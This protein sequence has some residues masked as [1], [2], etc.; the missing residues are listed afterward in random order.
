VGLGNKPGVQFTAF[1]DSIM[2]EQ[3][4]WSLNDVHVE[5]LSLKRGGA[6]TTHAI[7]E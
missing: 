1:F 2:Q 4:Q 7:I 5:G 3:Q 6:R